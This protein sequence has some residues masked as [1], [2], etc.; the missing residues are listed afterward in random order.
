MNPRR[1]SAEQIAAL[2]RDC[3]DELCD[4]VLELRDLVCRVAAASTEA[5]KFGCLCYFKPDQPYGV[6]GGNVCMIGWREDAVRLAFIHGAYLPD[7]EGLLKGSGKA[8]RYVEIR[9]RADIRQ[10]AVTHLIRAALAYTP[11]DER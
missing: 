5:V 9:S 6:I 1:L 4:L 11:E 2:L 10:P 3:P 8:K 7:P